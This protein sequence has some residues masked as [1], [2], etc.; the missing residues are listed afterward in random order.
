MSTEPQGWGEQP[1]PLHP[2]RDSR[3][4]TIASSSACLLLSI[5]L[6]LLFIPTKRAIAY[7]AHHLERLASAS[8]RIMA[9]HRLHARTPNELQ[10]A[11]GYHPIGEVSVPN[12]RDTDHVVRIAKKGATDKY[13]CW[14]TGTN[15]ET[16]LTMPGAKIDG[17]SGSSVTIPLTLRHSPRV[18]WGT[19]YVGD[20]HVINALDAGLVANGIRN[21][22]TRLNLILDMLPTSVEKTLLFPAGHFA[23]RGVINMVSNITMLGIRN[24]SFVQMPKGV[25][26]GMVIWYPTGGATG[27]D[28]MHD[29][30][31]RNITFRGE[32]HDLIPTQ[33]IYQPLIHA[34]RITYDS[35][36][37]MMVQRPFG[38]LL[39]VDGSTNVT[40]RN[41][42]VIGSPNRGQTFKEA[43]QMDVAALGA[44]GYYD[45]QTVF[46][47]LP[48]T[49]MSIIHNRFLPLRSKTGQL[50]LPAADPFGTHMAYARTTALSSYIRHGLFANNYVEDPAAF[51]G[52]G[53][54]NS[55][56]I[57]FDAAD[58]ITIIGNT[59]KWTGETPQPSWG[60]AFYARS[61]RM[62]K[63]SGW[64]GIT[65]SDNLF[66]NF[67]P[68]RG[69]FE[70][71]Q[72]RSSIDVPGRSVSAV[73]IQGNRFNGTPE[74]LAY[75]WL[76]D[77]SR[78]FIATHDQ[79]IRGLDNVV[80]G[81]I[82][83]DSHP[84]T[85]SRGTV[86]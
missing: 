76:R 67:A 9:A 30:T 74:R 38:H 2:A 56:V 72:E 4:L 64:R 41:S 46:D 29:V 39:D 65:I 79:R 10:Y 58:D 11:D 75:L 15:L 57:H 37:F 84:S 71:Y 43:F 24:E 3:L 13:V 80:N 25:H 34:N 55:A 23:F 27:Y 7:E 44:S 69:V 35:C 42:V 78:L 50:L 66:E 6:F 68:R 36:T 28:G 83:L 53:G 52:A 81:T 77:Y 54:Y 18:L 20:H 12:M 61:H 19:P 1:Q 45:R 51:E 5:A 48:T 17:I 63:P 60:V 32:Y 47:N 82:Y 70:L 86:A 73:H 49:N 85:R 22:T 14:T 26:G 16:S 31:W 62:V 33:T 21:N 59:F 8:S 40:V